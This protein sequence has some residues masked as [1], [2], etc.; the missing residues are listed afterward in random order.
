MTFSKNHDFDLSVP[1]VS[2]TPYLVQVRGFLPALVSNFELYLRDGHPDTAETFFE[3]AGGEADRWKAF[4]EK[5]L[6]LP[7]DVENLV[8]RY[9]DLTAKPF[10]ILRDVVDFFQPP[11]RIDD[12]VIDVVVT[13]ASL[14]TVRRDG[15]TW[16]GTTGVHATRRLEDFRFY[17]RIL[18]DELQQRASG[19]S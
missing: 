19:E 8:V 3:F 11:N 12:L 14:Q 17:D 10:A 5:W 15:E 1:I 7:V 13:A 9:E 18:F 2:G 6:H 4:A 16:V